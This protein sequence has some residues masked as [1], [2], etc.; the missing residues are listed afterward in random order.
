MDRQGIVTQYRT[1]DFFWVP[2]SFIDELAPCPEMRGT[3]VWVYNTL[4]RQ[5]TVW[6]YPTVDELVVLCQTTRNRVENVL[7]SC[8]E[9]GYL[10]YWDLQKIRR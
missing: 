7:D 6:D 5:A 9:A 1:K 2:N 3:G 10:N 4:A 8:A